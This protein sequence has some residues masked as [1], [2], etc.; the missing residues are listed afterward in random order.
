MSYQLRQ[1][2]ADKVQSIVLTGRFYKSLMS[3]L[4][5][6]NRAK[7]DTAENYYDASIGK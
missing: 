1:I 3:E 5:L 6:Q 7:S 2:D 4:N